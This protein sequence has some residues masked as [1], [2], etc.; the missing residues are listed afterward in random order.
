MRRLKLKKA[1][2][3]HRLF[4]EKKILSKWVGY[5]F[6]VEISIQIMVKVI[7]S[8]MSWAKVGIKKS[9]GWKVFSSR[10]TKMPLSHYVSSIAL[11]SKF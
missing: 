1:H 8:S 9:I 11:A 7:Y 5:T 10:R 6:S 2:P 4:I 3:V